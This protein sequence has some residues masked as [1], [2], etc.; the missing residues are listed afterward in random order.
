MKPQTE[1]KYAYTLEILQWII[2]LIFII[3]VILVFKNL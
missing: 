2:G 1:K 3:I